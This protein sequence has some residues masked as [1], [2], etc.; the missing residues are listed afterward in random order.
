MAI[1]Y[2]KNAQN[3]FSVPL[4]ALFVFL[5]YYFDIVSG[6]YVS[7]WLFCTIENMPNWHICIV[8][9]G[10]Y[11]DDMASLFADKVSDRGEDNRKIYHAKRRRKASD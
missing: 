8:V 4:Y 3:V 5:V 6:L 9:A 1:T 11:F 2:K 10:R 7:Y